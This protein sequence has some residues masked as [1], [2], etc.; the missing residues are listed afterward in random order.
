MNK[1]VY[2]SIGIPSNAYINPYRWLDPSK[3]NSHKMA[4]VR[5]KL[6]GASSMINLGEATRME[7]P[8]S[9][10]QRN[11]RIWNHS[12]S[13]SNKTFYV[14]VSVGRKKR[15]KYGDS[16]EPIDCIFCRRRKYVKLKH[17]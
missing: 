2:S 4:D 1:S 17:D 6:S 12:T 8:M 13:A 14:F 5:P 10:G 16:I 3:K 7:I 9:W 11:G 15:K